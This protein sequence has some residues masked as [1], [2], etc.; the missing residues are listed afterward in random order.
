MQKTCQGVESM[1]G[2]DEI[3]MV[4]T[5][6]P[7]ALLVEA[8]GNGREKAKNTPSTEKDGQLVALRV[9]LEKIE[10]LAGRLE[11]AALGMR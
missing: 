4:E 7:S 8:A 2:A 10:T 9:E 5:I 11:T 6:A 3:V 1:N